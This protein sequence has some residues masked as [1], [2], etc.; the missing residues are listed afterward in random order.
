[1]YNITAEAGGRQM[2]TLCM[3]V[4]LLVSRKI[5]MYLKIIYNLEK[6]EL[7]WVL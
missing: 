5:K 3:M 1:M 2:G 7:S 4:Q 6:N